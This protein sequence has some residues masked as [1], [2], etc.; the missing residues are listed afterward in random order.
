M[1]AE[2]YLAADHLYSMQLMF[3][4]MYIVASVN[5]MVVLLWVTHGHDSPPWW[6]VPLCGLLWPLLAPVVLGLAVLDWLH[7]QQRSWR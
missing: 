6:F 5:M 7:A 1:S 3:A 4:I 2:A